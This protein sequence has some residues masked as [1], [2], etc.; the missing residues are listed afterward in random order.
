M[1]EI[2]P[3]ILVKNFK[4]VKERIKQVKRFVNWIHLDIMDGIFVN[5]KTWPYTEG[6]IKDLKEISAC[7]RSSAGWKIKTKIEVHLMVEKPENVIDKWLEVVDRVI[8]HNE[9]KANN[10]NIVIQKLIKKVHK[11][12]KQIGLAINPETPIN[13][14]IPFLKKLDLVLIMTVKPGW[15]GQKFQEKTLEKIKDL[16]KIW[17]NHDIAIDGGI[18]PKSA[19]NA[20]QSGANIICS[21]TYIFENKDIKKAINN[22]KN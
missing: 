7:G 6:N 20:I 16:R 11:K 19:K 5:N 15:G 21:G 2:I 4:E 8:I 1:I 22:L 13:S 12:N 10:K 18:N 3:T 14:I 17:P 9:S